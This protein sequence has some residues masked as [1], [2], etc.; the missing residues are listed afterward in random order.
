MYKLCRG[1]VAIPLF[2][3]KRM[4]VQPVGNG[5][6]NGSLRFEEISDF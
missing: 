6:F 4:W 3:S 5:F 2:C 1:F